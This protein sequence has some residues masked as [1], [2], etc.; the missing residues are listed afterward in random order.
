MNA[1]TPQSTKPGRLVFVDGLRGVASLWVV[2][3]HVGKGGQ[4]EGLLERAPEPVDWVVNNGWLGV[5][6]FFVL[7]GFVISYSLES[8]PMS[9]RFF[10]HFVAKR[11][12]R[13]DPPYWLSMAVTV[14]VGVLSSVLKDDVY[15]I[16][17]VAQVAS[18][19]LYIQTIVEQEPIGEVY[20]TL[21]LEIQMYL[22]FCLFLVVCSWLGRSLRSRFVVPLLLVLGAAAANLY[23]L[24]LVEHR[25]TNLT[26]VDRVFFPYAYLFFTGVFVARWMIR[27]GD[28]IAVAM[29]FAQ[30]G[31]LIA[32]VVR[33]GS[34]T[35]RDLGLEGFADHGAR[36]WLGLLTAVAIAAAAKFGFM[37]RW[38]SSRFWQFLGRI[39]YSLYLIHVAVMGPFFWLAFKLTGQTLAWEAVWMSAGVA[40][41]VVAAWVFSKLIEDPSMRLAQRVPRFD[42]ARKAPRHLREKSPA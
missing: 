15:P 42:L 17:S 11:S 22:S 10:G 37:G 33:F 5:V 32:G 39:S 36:I 19:V 31:V 14:A 21:A 18:H 6:I 2:I 4:I 23:P 8:K 34:V 20:W 40:V 25:A 28:R 35:N 30:L 27:R 26:I 7:S 12:L 41:C 9:L 3:F 38:L 29:L 13:L 16:P 1:P 24:G